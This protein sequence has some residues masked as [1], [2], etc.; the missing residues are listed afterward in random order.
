MAGHAQSVEG[1]GRQSRILLPPSA[2][3]EK[4]R[5]NLEAMRR[6]AEATNRE[7]DR[8]AEEHQKLQ[9]TYYIHAHTCMHII[10][11]QAVDSNNRA[12][13]VQCNFVSE[14]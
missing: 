1:E 4:A 2:E 9:V 10:H 14:S 8:L 12:L 3:L 6:Q 7:Y 13:D 5:A 11:I